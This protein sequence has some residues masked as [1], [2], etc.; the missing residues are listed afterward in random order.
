LVD[1]GR[2]MM[3]NLAGIMAKADPYVEGRRPD[4]KRAELGL[5]KVTVPGPLT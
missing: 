3:R 2:N 5:A 1:I 4:P